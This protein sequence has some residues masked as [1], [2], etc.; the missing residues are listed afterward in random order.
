MT[1]IERLSEDARYRT[2]TQYRLWSYS[3]DSLASLRA[4]TTELAAMR[5]KEAISRSRE[6]A[7]SAVPSSADTSEAETYGDDTRKNAATSRD[8]VECLTAEEE[9]ELITFYCRQTIDLGTH[10]KVPAEVKV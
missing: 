5:V 7:N 8:E 2:S 4:T 6:S 10:L 9:L 3:P 1:Q